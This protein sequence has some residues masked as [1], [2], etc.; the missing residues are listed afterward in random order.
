MRKIRP[1]IYYVSTALSPEPEQDRGRE[2]EQGTR[3]DCEALEG[4]KSLKSFFKIEI[5]VN[6]HA[7]KRNNTERLLIHF[8]KW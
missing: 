8:A 2:K 7:V 3:R 6:S 1:P 4:R 5:T